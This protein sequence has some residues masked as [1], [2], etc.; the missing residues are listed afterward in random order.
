LELVSVTAQAVLED[1]LAFTELH[2][3]FCKTERSWIWAPSTQPPPCVQ[4]HL[5]PGSDRV[6]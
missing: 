2:L 3:V 5:S 4:R 1:P 6:H